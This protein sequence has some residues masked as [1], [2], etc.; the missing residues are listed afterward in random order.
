MGALS[1]VK[2][3]D[4]PTDLLISSPAENNGGLASISKVEETVGQKKPLEAAK[5]GQ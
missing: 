4:E 1:L 3:T 2:A 5:L